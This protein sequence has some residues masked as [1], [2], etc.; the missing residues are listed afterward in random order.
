LDASKLLHHLNPKERQSIFRKS[1]IFSWIDDWLFY[2]N[3]LLMNK[4]CVQEGKVHEIL[5]SCHDGPYGSHLADKRTKKKELHQ[6]YYCPTLFKDSKDYMKRCYSCQ[7]MGRPVRSYES[8]LRLQMV[9]QPFEKWAIAFVGP[10]NSPSFWHSY[11][12]VCMDYVTKWMEEKSLSTTI[13]WEVVEFIHEEICVRFKIPREIVND[14]GNHFTSWL[15]R[16]IC[17]STL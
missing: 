16:Y 1:E 15:I 9:L 14:R 6:G 2:T 8:M 5:K 7:C 3:P 13:E 11:I 4:I 17:V 12:L 10:I